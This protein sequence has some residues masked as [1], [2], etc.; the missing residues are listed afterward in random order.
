MTDRQN[1]KPTVIQTTSGGGANA[2]A[3]AWYMT[4][5]SSVVV[6]VPASNPV[7]APVVDAPAAPAAPAEAPAP[8]QP[9][10][11]A[12]AAPAAN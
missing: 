1:E 12:P 11:A 2:T 6:N 3:G 4:T 8:A 5:G 9:A 7:E 10:P